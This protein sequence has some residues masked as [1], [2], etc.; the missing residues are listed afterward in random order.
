MITSNLFGF[1]TKNNLKL[2]LFF[3]N[4]KSML[5]GILISKLNRFKLTRVRDEFHHLYNYF[6]SSRIKHPIACPYTHE[7]TSSIER[8]HHQITK[9]GLALLAHLYLPQQH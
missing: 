3:F 5:K 9:V 2:K 1:S 4:F 6:K 8:H 7:Q